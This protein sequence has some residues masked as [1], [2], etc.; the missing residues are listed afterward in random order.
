MFLSLCDPENR[1][2]FD[3][4]MSLIFRSN[5]DWR[6]CDTEN[7]PIERSLF[8]LYYPNLCAHLSPQVFVQQWDQG[9]SAKGMEHHVSDEQHVRRRQ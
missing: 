3:D 8:F 5:C 6:R 7:I 4:W 1:R 9:A 2:K